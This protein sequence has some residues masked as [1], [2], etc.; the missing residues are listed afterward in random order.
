[1]P[2]F[3]SSKDTTSTTNQSGT[4]TSQSSYAGQVSDLNQAFKDAMGAYSSA[5]GASAPSDFIASFSPEQL[6]SFRSM[7]G[8]GNNNTVPNAQANNGTSLSNAGTGGVNGALTGLQ[9]FDPTKNNNASSIVDTARHYMEGQNIPAQVKAAMQNATETARDVT[10]PGI[11]QNAAMTGN[12]NSSRTGVAEGIV[13]RSLAEQSANLE[14]SLT[15][16]SFK[17][18]LNLAQSQAQSNNNDQLAALNG[19]GA[20]GN[21]A[22]GTGNTAQDSSVKNMITQLSASANGGAGLTAAQQAQLDNAL[23]Q[24]QAGVTEPFAPLQQ[25]MSIIGGNY[26]QTTNTT[27]TSTTNGTTTNNPSLMS[28]IGSVAGA[29]SSFL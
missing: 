29:L 3:S 1:M 7:I 13:Q 28:D 17:D 19:Q 11:A 22:A 5:G 20:I 23:K 24:Y 14:N 9:G 26:G 21:A 6:Q 2:A 8:Y 25:L 27:G 16:Q 18:A 12:T 4:S 10:L 15:S